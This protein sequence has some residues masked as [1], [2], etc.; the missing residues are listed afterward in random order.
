M[1]AHQNLPSEALALE[2]LNAGRRRIAH[3]HGDLAEPTADIARLRG[4]LPRQLGERP[5]FTVVIGN[6][7]C[8]LRCAEDTDTTIDRLYI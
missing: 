1:S 3:F 8:H 5:A 7:F 6:R 4:R 2:H